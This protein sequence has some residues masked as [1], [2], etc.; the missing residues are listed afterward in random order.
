MKNEE[1]LLS[2]IAEKLDNKLF[3]YELFGGNN[4]TTGTIKEV[5]KVII[6]CINETLIEVY[7]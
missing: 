5:L 7:K 1:Y 4:Y 2:K 3:D 6:D